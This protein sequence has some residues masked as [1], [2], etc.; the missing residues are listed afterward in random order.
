M[1]T[2]VWSYTTDLPDITVLPL[3]VSPVS[4]EMLA[5]VLAKG[6]LIMPQYILVYPDGEQPSSPEEGERLFAN[7]RQ[8]PYSLREVTGTIE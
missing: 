2:L 5:G 8:W 4:K 7:H 6:E 1:S 3:T